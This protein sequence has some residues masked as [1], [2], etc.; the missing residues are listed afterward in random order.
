ME[1]EATCHC[2]SPVPP[3]LV[4]EMGG[5]QGG[6]YDTLFYTKPAPR[7]PIPIPLIPYRL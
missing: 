5:P 6:S 1:W 2:E 4:F 3:F 7:L